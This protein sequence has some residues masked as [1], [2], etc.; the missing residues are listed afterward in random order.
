MHHIFDGVIVCLAHLIFF[1]QV[2]HENCESKVFSPTLG[3]NM[4]RKVKI[5]FVLILPTRVTSMNESC[6]RT[7]AALE[8]R[9]NCHANK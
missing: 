8:K 6:V 1:L 4:L 9:W 5:L 7:P 3:L 2:P